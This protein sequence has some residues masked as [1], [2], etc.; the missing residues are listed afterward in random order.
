M[1]PAPWRQGRVP[2]GASLVYGVSVLLQC[3][4]RPAHSDSLTRSASRPGSSRLHRGIDSQTQRTAA[5]WSV[6][7]TFP[8]DQQSGESSRAEFPCVPWACA[9]AGRTLAG[10]SR[11]SRQAV[12]SIAL[13]SGAVAE[14]AWALAQGVSLPYVLPCRFRL[15]LRWWNGSASARAGDA[16]G[17]IQP[18]LLG[19]LPTDWNANAKARRVVAAAGPG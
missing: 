9:E 12:G 8:S 2:G 15:R 17:R 1:N 5:R 3:Q 6:G 10:R 19:Q 18:Q 7:A 13:A 4:H 11:P 16:A 14:A